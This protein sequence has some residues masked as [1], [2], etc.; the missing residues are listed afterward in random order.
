M[1]D[2]D[3][4]T[5]GPLEWDPGLTEEA[6]Q[7]PPA[8]PAPKRWTAELNEMITSLPQR[9]ITLRFRAKMMYWMFTGAGTARED[10]LTKAMMARNATA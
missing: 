8:A 3:V 7:G 1:T 5:Q 4:P 9:E 2:M 6:V 10:P